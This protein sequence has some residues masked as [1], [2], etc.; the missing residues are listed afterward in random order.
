MNSRALVPI[1]RTIIAPSTTDQCSNTRTSSTPRLARSLPVELLR[2]IFLIAVGSVINAE[3]LVTTSHDEQHAISLEVR[4]KIDKLTTIC[5]QWKA[6]A[7]DVPDLW[8][9]LDFSD[10]HYMVQCLSLCKIRPLHIRGV[11]SSG[12]AEADYTEVLKALETRA[13]QIVTISVSTE[14]MDMLLVNL[15]SITPLSAFTV[16][17]PN[18]Q[19][20][21]LTN[22]KKEFADRTD[23]NL[24]LPQLKLLSLSK[25]GVLFSASDSSVPALPALKTLIITFHEITVGEMGNLVRILH[26]SPNLNAL[27]INSGEL[28][29]R[30][31][32]TG[33]SLQFQRLAN[34]RFNLPNLA[35]VKF[36]DIPGLLSSSICYALQDSQPEI[37]FVFG[38]VVSANH[39][40][41][42]Y[43]YISPPLE[44]LRKCPHACE[45]SLSIGFQCDSPDPKVRFMSLQS[46]KCDACAK[47]RLLI[48]HDDTFTSLLLSRMQ[49]FLHL[50]NRI[51]SL[52]VSLSGVMLSGNTTKQTLMWPHIWRDLHSLKSV[53]LFD[54]AIYD[55][56]SDSQRSFMSTMAGGRGLYLDHLEE[57]EVSYI[58]GAADHGTWPGVDVRAVRRVVDACESLR[59]VKLHRLPEVVRTTAEW[60]R[61]WGALEAVLM[62]RN[63]S[64]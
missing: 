64:L 56:A 25:V 19:E 58:P 27:M 53:R 18:L 35:T 15:S 47:P 48:R 34:G 63:F 5:S 49:S 60:R 51:T 36:I 38:D 30:M 39:F 37:S 21:R 17:L 32:D 6:I 29:E 40:I 59:E 42:D 54:V 50:D 24:Y 41:V 28:G 62:E 22:M 8:T 4:K 20:L 12:K 23:H 55:D 43:A 14:Q 7:H 46:P 61:R 33:D 13:E 2:E 10:P 45:L 57:L 11:F 3:N 16:F 31:P 1:L 26:N 9:T 52:N 44:S